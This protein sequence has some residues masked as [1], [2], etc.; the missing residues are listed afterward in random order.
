MKFVV[1]HCVPRPFLRY[2]ED[3]DIQRAGQMGWA[4]HSNGKL[5]AAAEAAGYDALITVDKGFATQQKIAGRKISVLL[6]DTQDTELKGLI[7]MVEML[8]APMDNLAPGTLVRLVATNQ[9]Y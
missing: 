7:P 2:L 6:L 5:L 4:E 1:D 3:Y 8:R 9:A